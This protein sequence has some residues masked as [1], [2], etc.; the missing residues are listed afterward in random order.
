MISSDMHKP[1]WKLI[2]TS[3]EYKLTNE[4]L[5]FYLILGYKT[6]HAGTSDEYDLI[7]FQV[8]F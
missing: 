4:S 8:A 7:C 5:L 3:N 1:L 2:E 6:A